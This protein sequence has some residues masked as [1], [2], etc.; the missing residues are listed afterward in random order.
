[1][2][3]E[4]YR[5]SHSRG[6]LA[7]RA[8]LLLAAAAAMLAGCPMLSPVAT[9][10]A[11]TTRA[12]ADLDQ[13]CRELPDAL[14]AGR[15]FLIGDRDPNGPVPVVFLN[16]GDTDRQV[17]QPPP[18]DANAGVG[19]RLLKTAYHDRPATTAAADY[20]WCQK[21]VK[22]FIQAELA[23]NRKAFA[24]MNS[25]HA[26]SRRVADD[27]AAAPVM[28]PGLRVPAAVASEDWPSYCLCELRVALLTGNLPSARDWSTELAAALAA[29]CD[30]HRWDELLNENIMASLEF[31]AACEDLFVNT[32]P[33]A[34]DPYGRTMLTVFPGGSLLSTGISNFGEIERQAQAMFRCPAIYCVFLR[35]EDLTA[36][37][38]AV[39]MP[40]DLRGA[41]TRMR[42]RLSAANQAV[43]DAAAAGPFERSFIV[44]MLYRARRANVLEP[45][46][47]SLARFDRR[48]PSAQTWQLMDA[49][50]YRAGL[51]MA[52]L[53]WGDRFDKRLMALGADLAGADPAAALESARVAQHKVYGGEKNYAGLVLSLRRALDTGKMDCIR[54][55]DMIA[56]LCRNAG[57][58]GFVHVRWSRGVS[59]HSVAGM[60]TFAPDGGRTI[61]IVDGLFPGGAHTGVWP[62]S[63][64]KDQRDIYAAELFGRGLD[65][66][67]WMEGYIVRGPAAGTLKR[68]A[69]PYLPGPQHT[70]S[71]KVYDVPSGDRP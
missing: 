63:Y 68:F 57:W 21:N 27:L 65:S 11:P 42:S 54:A 3:N 69:V 24:A 20:E 71:A 55:T 17:P 22:D 60:T 1:M 25:L 18:G 2:A 29:L 37:P 59:G 39:F 44:N 51:S 14:A 61:N 43:L 66:V 40:P 9:T 30:L 49:M 16:P 45:L 19:Y 15:K 23:A 5:V 26:A 6:P 70:D 10:A 34:E 33:T 35:R 36:V 47:E 7:W 12:S 64:Y 8:W 31:Q 48:Y 52:G 58:P 28:P 53:E 4:E 13:L 41:Y 67:I 50:V 38:A 46:G 56:A 32:K 62:N